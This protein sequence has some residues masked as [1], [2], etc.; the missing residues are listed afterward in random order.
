MK[1]AQQNIAQLPEQCYGVILM[2]N[3]LMKIKAGESGY[4]NIGQSYPEKVCEMDEITMSE[5][6]DK[7]NAENN[8][9]KGMRVAME[10][11]SMFGWEARGADV[12]TYTEDGQYIPQ[13]ENQKSKS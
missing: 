1:T 9:T 13:E 6:A 11:G 3:S 2:D 4:Y 7:W 12:D 5:L 10:T 8:V